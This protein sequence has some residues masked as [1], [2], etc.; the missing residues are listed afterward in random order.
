M[1]GQEEMKTGQ[2]TETN[3]QFLKEGVHAKEQS[4]SEPE[5]Y[6]KVVKVRFFTSRSNVHFILL[7]DYVHV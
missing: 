5:I 3:C 1:I 2:I 6:E 7:E 4:M